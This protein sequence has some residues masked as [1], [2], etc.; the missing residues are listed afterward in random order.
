M[1]FVQMTKLKISKEQ[2]SCDKQEAKQKV[3]SELFF[4]VSVSSNKFEK[5]RFASFYR[6]NFSCSQQK[7][8]NM[9]N[10]INAVITLN[11][12]ISTDEKEEKHVKT[13]E[14]LVM[15]PITINGML[16]SDE[17]LAIIKAL[18]ADKNVIVD[19]VP[20]CGKSALVLFL[21]VMFPERYNFQ[22]TYNAALKL[23][24][25]Q[26]A[27]DL[28]LSNLEV[29][30][31]HSAA[32]KYYDSKVY[33]DIRMQAMLDCDKTAR[34]LPATQTAELDEIQDMKPLYRLF[35]Q[36]FFRDLRQ[37]G[38]DP[39]LLVMG[40][41]F[42]GVYAFLDADERYLTLGPAIW[43]NLLND[44]N[45]ENKRKVD[46]A[47]EKESVPLKNNK[48]REI[49]E[50]PLSMSFRLTNQM[51]EFV[52][53]CVLG[54]TRIRACR[55]G[56][57]VDYIRQPAFS[58]YRTVGN[59]LIALLRAKKIQP[60]DIFILAPTLR[61][62]TSPVRELEKMFLNAGY[63]VFVTLNDDS[64]LDE[65]LMRGKIVFCTFC[66]VKGRE[67][68]YVVVFGFGISYFTYFGKD[69]DPTQ[70]PAAIY[71][72]ITRA[73]EHLTVLEDTG[74]SSAGSSS[75]GSICAPLPFL[76]LLEVKKD[77]TYLN[78]IGVP[79][80]QKF[81]QVPENNKPQKTSPSEIVKFLQDRYQIR[82]NELCEQ[83]YQ[84]YA[85]AHCNIPIETKVYREYKS[86]TNDDDAASIIQS[87]DISDVN[88]T[89]I[90]AMLE[91]KWKLRE[92]G[93]TSLHRIIKSEVLVDQE[94][95]AMQNQILKIKFPCTT[96]EEYLQLGAVYL[97][98]TSG[99]HF[100]LA[101]IDSYD[102]LSEDQVEACH[103]VMETHIEPTEETQF[104]LSIDSYSYLCDHGLVQFEHPRVDCCDS[105]TVWEFK[106][107]PQLSLEDRL[108]LV[109]Y[110]W[111]WEK[112]MKEDHGTREFRLMNIRS[113]EVLEMKF[114]E[115][116][117]EKIMF[118][119]IENLFRIQTKITDDAFVEMANTTPFRLEQNEDE[120]K[121]E[122][123]KKPRQTRK[124]KEKSEDVA[125]KN[126]FT[127]QSQLSFPSK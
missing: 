111:L 97:A 26:K 25:R 108:Q 75:K 4:G 22:I 100:K 87:E 82:L 14:K 91:A 114:N 99:Y 50:L 79:P 106:C 9:E 70:C 76:K 95:K 33:D 73:S 88:G 27:V 6:I 122:K 40:D 117:V 24:V 51:A 34:K 105:N 74:G 94:T 112:S 84:E 3:K 37:Q 89:I 58:S 113:G 120:R 63:P 35:I 23:E 107:K 56:P 85:P 60:E 28:N 67:R 98:C 121:E 38:S 86:S 123:V 69:L 68:K 11:N 126:P 66:S 53:K 77:S 48:E 41:R 7:G 39:N 80:I 19:G 119:L 81:T 17:Q 110:A 10:N 78:L 102:W 61:G 18:V 47:E 2:L 103:N 83:L 90:P 49:V 45:I 20:G 12:N 16:P 44:S 54:Y 29:H 42:Q 62:Q 96:I 92:N 32:V 31:Y 64:R 8:N 125:K 101:Q 109:V 36:K 115:E 65:D 46:D 1:F 116:I 15:T 93:L 55:D 52:N 71:V 118:L 72:A 104:E 57:R 5:N 21:A 30:S 13:N 127:K 124:R 43:K 59:R